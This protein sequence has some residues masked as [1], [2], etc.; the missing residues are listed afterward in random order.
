[1]VHCVSAFNLQLT[2][3]ALHHKQLAYSQQL[4]LLGFNLQLSQLTAVKN[5]E[6]G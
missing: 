1:M 4:T 3:T 6:N 5:N 2:K